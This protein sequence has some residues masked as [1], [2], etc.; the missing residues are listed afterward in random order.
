MKGLD[1][2][3]NDISAVKQQALP[4]AGQNDAE[5]KFNAKVTENYDLLGRKLE[6]L[7]ENL[8]AWI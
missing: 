7:K 4:L 6:A 1:Q 2:C 8:V 3:K 5:D